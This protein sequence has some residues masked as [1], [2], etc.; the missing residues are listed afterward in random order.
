MKLVLDIYFLFMEYL[1][2]REYLPLYKSCKL[3]YNKT[4]YYSYYINTINIS[5]NNVANYG[6]FELIQMMYNI[7]RPFNRYG[8]INAIEGGHINI[9]IYLYDRCIIKKYTIYDSIYENHFYMVKYIMSKNI[10]KC[11]DFII[12]YANKFGTPE[13]INYINEYY[14]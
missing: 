7:N 8:I 1:S 2:Y 10:I 13:I 9:A 11:K 3:L 4:R 5:I 6:C 14:L 12:S